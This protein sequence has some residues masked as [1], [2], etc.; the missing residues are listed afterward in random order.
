MGIASSDLRLFATQL[1]HLGIAT[2]CGGV[3]FLGFRWLSTQSGVIGLIVAGGIICRAFL[4][5]LLFWVSYLRLPIARSLQLGGGFWT[6]TPDAR[7][8]YGYASI[9]ADSRLVGMNPGDSSPFFVKTLAVWMRLVGISPAAGLFLNLSMYVAICVLLVWTFKPKNEWRRDL[10]CVLAVAAFSFSPVLLVHGTQPLKEDLFTFLITVMCLGVLMLVRLVVYGDSASTP[11][12]K[13]ATALLVVVVAEYC[14]AGIRPYYAV[15]T[16]L[17]L[18]F[19]LSMFLFLWRRRPVGQYSLAGL[20]ILTLLWFAYWLGAGPSYWGPTLS[21]TPHPTTAVAA[22]ERVRTGFALTGGN[23]NMTV[24]EDPVTVRT[25]GIE[26]RNTVPTQGRWTRYAHGLLVGLGAIFVPIS[27]L[28]N[29]GIVNFSGG[30]GLLPIADLDAIF[31]DVSLLGVLSLLCARK[32]QIG[33]RLPFV[34]FALTLSVLSAGLLA[35]VVTN[36]GS[37]FRM[38][39]MIAVPVWVACLAMN[40]IKSDPKPGF[41]ATLD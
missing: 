27:L 12:V 5:L 20:V 34:I 6:V 41:S 16:W 9:A 14:I 18:A 38:K 24:P 30:R 39:S 13:L 29:L 37:L 26:A 32:R 10:P 7:A 21:S 11:Q 36:F 35:Y 4:G 15:M 40:S 22:L 1:T 31:L 25:G 3:L 19:V 2:I 23:T 28:K 33:T 8:Y 17:A